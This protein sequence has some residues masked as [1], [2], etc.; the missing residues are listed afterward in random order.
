MSSFGNIVV[1][2][3]LVRRMWI[4][5]YVLRRVLYDVRSDEFNP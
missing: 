5:L 2:G 4:V 1:P 3:K